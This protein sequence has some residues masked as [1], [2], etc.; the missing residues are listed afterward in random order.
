VA[1]IAVVA[2]STIAGCGC[3]CDNHLRA[4]DFGRTLYPT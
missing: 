2:P 1:A 3:L 4:C